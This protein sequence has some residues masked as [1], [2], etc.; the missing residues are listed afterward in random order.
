MLYPLLLGAAK[1]GLGNA[2][3]STRIEL[4]EGNSQKVSLVISEREYLN[5]TMKDSRSR[6]RSSSFLGH[7]ILN[8]FFP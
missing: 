4:V 7:A 8:D 5:L 3:T 6:E 1:R 2:S